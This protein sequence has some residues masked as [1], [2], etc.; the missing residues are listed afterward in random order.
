[1]KNDDLRLEDLASLRRQVRQLVPKLRPQELDGT[2]AI[3]LPQ[4]A[5]DFMV[6][7]G[8]SIPVPPPVGPTDYEVLDAEY[9]ELVALLEDTHG[10]A[11]PRK[12]ILVPEVFAYRLE[13]REVIAYRRLFSSVACDRQLEEFLLRAASLRRRNEKQ[14][15]KIQGLL[16]DSA[17][18]RE[19]PVFTEGRRITRIGDLFI[20]RFEHLIEQLILTGDAEEA[21]SL[22]VLRVRTMRSF[23]GLWLLVHR[24]Y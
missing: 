10:A 12:V 18:I 16:D 20:H 19:G 17:T 4:E 15:E 5:R 2:G 9:A 1:M 6:E 8:L 21:R 13:P 24:S 3:A 7:E 23:S 22:Q 14:V 11:D